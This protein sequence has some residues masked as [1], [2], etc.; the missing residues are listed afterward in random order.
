MNPD[1]MGA[2]VGV[3]AEA[4]ATYAHQIR[5]LYLELVSHGF[6][7]EQALR[8]ILATWGQK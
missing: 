5:V 7:E 1:D 2:P 8:I 4:F 3:S 6:T